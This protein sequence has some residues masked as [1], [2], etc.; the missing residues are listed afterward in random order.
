[1]A[2][3][4]AK[5][6]WNISSPDFQFVSAQSWNPFASLR[7]LM[8]HVRGIQWLRYHPHTGGDGPRRN[9]PPIS[10]RKATRKGRELT[11]LLPLNAVWTQA[12]CAAPCCEK[13]KA[14]SHQQS[15]YWVKPD[16]HETL[17][18]I[19]TSGSRLTPHS[20]DLWVD[21]PCKLSLLRAYQVH[22]LPS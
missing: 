10:D 1:M 4:A 17:W 22:Q 21:F 20:T 14:L 2:L 18:W 3:G 6:L 7:Y 15:T 11:L 16:P 13:S 8:P 12:G 9:G 5:G 19:V